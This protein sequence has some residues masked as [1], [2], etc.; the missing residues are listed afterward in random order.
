M[1]EATRRCDEILDLLEKE[2][3]LH[4]DLLDLSRREQSHLVTLDTDALAATLRDI[5]ELAGKIRA[6]MQARLALI[7]ELAESLYPGRKGATC[8]EALS[9]GG[10]NRVERYRSMLECLDPILEE[11]AAINAGNIVLISNVLDYI[12]FATRFLAN[13]HGQNTYGVRKVGR[14]HALR[15]SRS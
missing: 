4:R 13:R 2:I 10:R 3:G 15:V 7:A 6:T 12:D 8:E 14:P 1:E 5:E 11:H 9:S